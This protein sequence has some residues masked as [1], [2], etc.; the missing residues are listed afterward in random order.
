MYMLRHVYVMTCVYTKPVY[1]L[2]TYSYTL[3]NIL[4]IPYVINKIGATCASSPASTQ[5]WRST[6]TTTSAW[7]VQYRDKGCIGVQVYTLCIVCRGVQVQYSVHRV[8]RVY[9]GIDVYVDFN[10]YEYS[11]VYIY[12]RY[13][14]R[15][16]DIFALSHT[17]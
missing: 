17:S 7:Q 8:C 2:N 10:Y 1:T 12:T 15:Y 11:V 6:A 9:R 14:S 16:I 13:L 3:Y 5:R 4:Y